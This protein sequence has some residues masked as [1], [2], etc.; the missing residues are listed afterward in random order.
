MCKVEN[1]YSQLYSLEAEIA[2]IGGLLLKPDSFNDVEPILS[3]QDFYIVQYRHIFDAISLFSQKNKAVDILTL[4]EYFKEKGMLD[5]IG[6][7]AHLAEI[8]NGTPSAANVVAYAELVRRYSKQRQYLSLGRFIIS[9]MNKPKNTEQLEELAEKIEKQYTNIALNQTD[10]GAANLGDIFTEMFIK[11]EKSALNADPITGTPLG[12]QTIDE[13]TTGGQGGELIILAARPGMGKTAL[14]LTAAASTL[15]K[16]TTQPIFYFSQEMPADQ[17]LQRFMAMKSRV[18]LQKIRRATELEDEDWGKIAN[19]VHAIQKNWTNRLI[20]DDEGA[21]TVQRLRSKVRQYC[22][23]YGQPAAIFI[24]YLQLMRGTGKQ[25]NRH[26]EITHI[27]GALKALAKE[28][29]R[30]IYALSQLNRSLEQ[31]TNKRPVNADLRESGSLEQD[32]D[33]ILFIYRDEIY[34]PESEAKG[35]AEII[36]GKQR[37][38][39]LGKVECRFHGEFSLFE[40]EMNLNGYRYE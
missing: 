16:F 20:I 24:D 8:V 17:L 15:D 30:P 9:E 10:N 25:E 13:L 39:P 3:S 31:R 36:I 21:L 35:L 28:L 34:H 22:R 26:L 32:A 18:S 12:I 5:D 40:N 14:S 1:T 38:G 37:N 33:V 6:G 2:V 27:S 23:Q 11:M 4:S 29:G 7:F 19:A